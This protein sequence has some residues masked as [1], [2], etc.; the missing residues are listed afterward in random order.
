MHVVIVGG[1]AYG[2]S[3]EDADSLAALVDRLEL[4]DAVTMTGQVADAGPYIDQMDVL[5]NASD[6]E[7]FGIVLLEGMARGVAVVA[8]D[9]GGPA[10]FIVDGETG[11]LARSGE[12]EDLA[13]ALEPLLRSSERRRTLGLAGR[14]RFMRDFT[15][16]AMRERF[17]RELEALLPRP[18]GTSTHD[19]SPRLQPG[20]TPR[21]S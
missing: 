13:D 6:P 9:S 21:A 16:V 19:R 7:P 2:S 10:E 4:T 14:D 17:F 12:P 8:V 20:E 11:V 5:V 3:R 15:D 18:N 1:A